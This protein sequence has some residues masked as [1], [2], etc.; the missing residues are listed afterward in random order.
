MSPDFAAAESAAF[1][2]PFRDARPGAGPDAGTHLMNRLAAE[3]LDLPRLAGHEAALLQR[4]R[5][6][7]WR[8]KERVWAP[9]E[10]V[11]AVGTWCAHP[12]HL[13]FGCGV[14]SAEDG[15]HPG[16][17]E[18]LARREIGTALGFALVLGALTVAAHAVV[19]HRDGALLRAGAEALGLL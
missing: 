15:L 16:G 6:R 11:T 4:L 8:L 18:R 5:E 14:T 2:E 13:D 17:S 1:C 9:G 7:P 19:W 12:P 10:T 3:A